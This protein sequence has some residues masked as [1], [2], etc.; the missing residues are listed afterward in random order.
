MVDAQPRQ[1]R[2]RRFEGRERGAVGV[3]LG[4][5]AGERVHAA[6]EPG[7]QRPAAVQVEAHRAHAGRV[8]G[9]DLGVGDVRRELGDADEAGAEPRQR[10]EE[11]ALVDALERAGHHGA[12]RDREARRAPR[13][14]PAVA[15][16]RR[17]LEARR[18]AR[19]SPRP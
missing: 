17:A 9:Q 3:D 15:G 14:G 12:A 7:V 11:P 6:G 19:G 4:V 16:P 18:R 10:V 2:E 1:R 8:Q 13:R 5:P